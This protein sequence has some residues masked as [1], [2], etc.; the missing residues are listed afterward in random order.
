M[1][2]GI[3]IGGTKI[4]VLL[5]TP[6]GEIVQRAAFPTTDPMR[7][8]KMAEQ[9]LTSFLKKHNETPQAVGISCGGPLDVERGLIQSPPNLPG[10]DN[11]AVIRYFQQAFG[12]PVYLENDANAGA[13]AEWK[14]GA[15]RGLSS[16]VFLTLGTGLGAGLI[17]DGK[18]YRGTAGLA[19]ELGHW[20]LNTHGP[21]G[22]GKAGSFEGFCSGGGLARLAQFL[23]QN[24][25]LTIPKLTARD[26]AGLARK[27]DALA[28]EV[29]RISGEYLGRGLAILLDLL[30]PQAVIIGS[31]FC[32]CEDLL[33]A[34]MERTLEEEA[35]A[36]AR[37]TAKILPAA[38][39]E[40]IGDYAAICIAREGMGWQ[41]KD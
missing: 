14:M 10:W 37:E 25:G 21:E 20:R 36:S 4:A 3:D 39:G 13:L 8:L 38:L 31:M 30:N 2:V 28:L 33:R 32:R 18:L 19:G 9:L 12:C 29:F 5:A 22:Y 1:I 34:H 15:G 26:L 35:L 40:Q 16:L 23:A 41:Q 24:H 17:L 7:S 6:Q 11:V 27:G